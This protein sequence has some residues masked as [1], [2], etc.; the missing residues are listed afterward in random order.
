MP[1]AR[2]RYANL[3]DDSELVP[4]SGNTGIAGGVPRTVQPAVQPGT[5]PGGWSY[6][7][8]AQSDQLRQSLNLPTGPGYPGGSDYT[9]PQG[10]DYQSWFM[11][12]LQGKPFN[13]QTLLE[14]EPTLNRFGFHLTPPNAAGERTKIQ[15]PTGEWVRVGFGEGHP[16]WNVQNPGGGGAAASGV[17][18]VGAGSGNQWSAL[19]GEL[20]GPPPFEFPTL[21]Q[22][23]QTP[24]YQAR[25]SAGQNALEHSAAAKGSLLSGGFQKS[26]NRYAQDFASN[27]YQ[28]A[29]NNYLNRY[30]TN[31]A[32]QS[33]LPWNRYLDLLGTGQNATNTLAGAGKVPLGTF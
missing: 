7:T 31:V 10:G 25:L 5:A 2:N 19:A 3:M 24:G 20:G 12:L 11:N 22:L 4:A 33:Q 18:G 23:Q 17:L 6:A 9:A 8:P 26:L 28:N 32:T 15:L 27:E 14:L 30:N 13:Q 1:N 16:V 21:D 29:Y